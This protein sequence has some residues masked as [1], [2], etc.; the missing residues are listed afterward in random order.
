MSQDDGFPIHYSAV[1]R[2]TPVYASDGERVGVVDEVVDN[3]REHILD[4]IV[5][6]G[7]DGKLRF[8][9]APEVARTAERA[10]RLSIGAAAAAQLPPPEK[11]S[12]NFTPRRT[13][14]LGK[15]L[16]G[17]WRRR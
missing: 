7:T 1:K 10:V 14:R 3:Y 12:P 15:L 13:G 11:A 9:D 17:S 5:I 4:G 2:G 16:G 8:V 6:D